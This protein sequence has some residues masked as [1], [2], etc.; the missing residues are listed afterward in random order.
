M[1]ITLGNILLGL[2]VLVGGLATFFA[3]R[4]RLD[5]LDVHLS[6]LNARLMGVDKRL[7]LL[8]NV[9]TDIAVQDKR[10]DMI[11]SMIEDMRHGRGFTFELGNQ[12]SWARGPVEPSKR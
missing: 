12:R 3:M 9:L 6:G 8:S 2:G 11:E 4:S 10:L 5:V 1:T 7:D